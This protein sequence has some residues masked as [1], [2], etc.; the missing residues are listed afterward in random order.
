M[1]VTKLPVCEI[2]QSFIKL[3]SLESESKKA[4][5]LFITLNGNVYVILLALEANSFASGRF[6][7]TND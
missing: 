2:L 5:T 6:V 4:G 3:F 7:V 1:G